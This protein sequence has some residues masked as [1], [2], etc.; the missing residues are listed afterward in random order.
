MLMTTYLEHSSENISETTSFEK[1]EEP[2]NKWYRPS[3]KCNLC[4]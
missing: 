3:Y 4:Y 2:F 1:F